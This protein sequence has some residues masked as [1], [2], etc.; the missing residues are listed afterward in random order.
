MP[1]TPN[2]KCIATNRT[3][4][5]PGQHCLFPIHYCIY[6]S[7]QN[8][9]KCRDMVRSLLRKDGICPENEDRNVSFRLYPEHPLG[10]ESAL[11]GANVEMR[12]S[13]QQKFLF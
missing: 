10:S 2:R 7:I 1:Y 11:Y 9:S 12:R 8:W 3:L 5:L 13:S 6:N 4:T